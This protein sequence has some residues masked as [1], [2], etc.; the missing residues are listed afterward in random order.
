MKMKVI[1]ETVHPSVP[2]RKSVV[3]DNHPSA[4]HMKSTKGM[5]SVR[6]GDIAISTRD[7]V[8]GMMI[9]YFTFSVYQHVAVFVW[10]DRNE[11]AR[12]GK[13]VFVA[14]CD[15]DNTLLTLIHITKRRMYDL[16]T[17]TFRN[18]L[19]LCD[20]NTYAKKN[21]ITVWNRALSTHISDDVATS[22]VERFMLDNHAML[23][24]ENDI[25]TILA[26][27]IGIVYHPYEHRMICT[28]MICRYLES[29]YGYPF[30]ISEK[31]VPFDDTPIDVGERSVDF[32]LP[33]REYDVYRARDFRET[34]NESPVFGGKEYV[35]YGD[36]DSAHFSTFHPFSVV[37]L[38]ILIS[39]V[40][41]IA[42]AC[43]F[44]SR[45]NRKYL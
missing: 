19:V 26:V 31:G 8:A 10:I 14:R 1:A 39:I 33:Y 42:I 7:D 2:N 36:R 27:P 41:V 43:V 15:G 18:G 5:E 28:A 4:K 13:V 45:G 12:T 25:R 30:L 40:I 38:M 22:C 3:N 20:F 37:L 35:V 23:E 21:L 44:M 16:Y 29:S 32:I 24:Y 6:T 9:T 11:Y 17:D 34:S